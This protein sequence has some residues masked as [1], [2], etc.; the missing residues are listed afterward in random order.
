MWS[1][2]VQAVSLLKS[3]SSTH[4]PLSSQ[5]CNDLC[6]TLVPFAWNIHMYC[7][8]I[9][10]AVSSW[11]QSWQVYEERGLRPI[12]GTDP[13]HDQLIYL[14]FELRQRLYQECG[15]KGWTIAQCIG[16]AIFIPAGAPHQV[17]YLDSVVVTIVFLW[18]GLPECQWLSVCT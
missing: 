3:T 14:D 10:T 17:S 15:V 4:Q 8:S 7:C 11:S 1:L 9:W 6:N 18:A 2:I 13:I 5:L 16:D 12:S